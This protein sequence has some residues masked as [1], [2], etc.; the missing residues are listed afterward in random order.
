MFL[1]V[2]AKMIVLKPEESFQGSILV[3]RVFSNMLPVLAWEITVIVNNIHM[4]A[5]PVVL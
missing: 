3:S 1:L 5:L 4:N 2:N